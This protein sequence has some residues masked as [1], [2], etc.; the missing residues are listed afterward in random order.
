[1]LSRSGLKMELCVKI[2][3][4]PQAASAHNVMP[5]VDIIRRVGRAASEQAEATTESAEEEER[6]AAE[7]VGLRSS[8][9]RGRKPSS[10]WR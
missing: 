8:K 9:F 3:D 1:M 2:I 7:E 5:V 4:A 6:D 10:L